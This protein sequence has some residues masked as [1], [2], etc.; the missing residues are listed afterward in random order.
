MDS[1]CGMV[2]IVV[3]KIVD[4]GSC[5]KIGKLNNNKWGGYNV[6]VNPS[7]QRVY[8]IVSVSDDASMMG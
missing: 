5:K 8:I 1:R 6:S 2:V 7:K 3:M 4:V